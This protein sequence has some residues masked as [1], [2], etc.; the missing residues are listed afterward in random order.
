MSIDPYDWPR[1]PSRSRSRSPA[2]SPPRD[3]PHL[4]F[5]QGLVHA[6]SLLLN[7][8]GS[9]FKVHWKELTDQLP[10]TI[11]KQ[12]S[13]K[14]REAYDD[15]K[16]VTK[17]VQVDAVFVAWVNV[18]TLK[19]GAGTVMAIR[20]TNSTEHVLQDI[21]MFLHSATLA[22]LVDALCTEAQRCGATHVCGHSLGGFLA[23]A[24]ASHLNLNGASFC[25]PGGGRG[26]GGVFGMNWTK[27]TQ[28]EV[29]CSKGDAV[30]E[31]AQQSHIAERQYHANGG[32]HSIADMDE[33]IQ[34]IP[35][36]HPARKR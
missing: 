2:P 14:A 30:S 18:T 12:L 4:E 3:G 11:L 22:P 9:T 6:G 36:N 8:I 29:H 26:L 33:S 25:G 21:L 13:S 24:V 15:I 19:D 27:D 35:L 16:N 5:G 7:P 1:S 31:Y 20:G 17:K 34:D 28:F 32:S 10:L 23:E